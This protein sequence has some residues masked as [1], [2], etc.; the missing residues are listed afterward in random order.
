MNTTTSQQFDQIVN[1]ARFGEHCGAAF[2]TGYGTCHNNNFQNDI[3][4][5]SSCEKEMFTKWEVSNA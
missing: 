5:S 1:E 3:I 4:F 2:I